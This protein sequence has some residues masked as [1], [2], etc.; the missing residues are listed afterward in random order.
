MPKNKQIS[1]FPIE[2]PLRK[3]YWDVLFQKVP[4]KP[5]VYCFL[6]SM[7]KV[8]YVGKA[9]NLRQ[10]LASYRFSNTMGVANKSLHLVTNAASLKW[11]VVASELH[12][13]IE[14]DRLIKYYLPEFN[15]VNT[16]FE[17]YYFIHLCKTAQPLK[18]EI[19]LSMS[20]ILPNSS[21]CLG[22]FKGHRQT[23]KALGAIL[24]VLFFLSLP[25]SRPKSIPITLLRKLTPNTFVVL[26]RPYTK[27]RLISFLKGK[28]FCL[29]KEFE[30]KMS[31]MISK[32]S[33][34]DAMLLED[35]FARLYSFFYKSCRP[36]NQNIGTKAF[37]HK[38]QLD[39]TLIKWSNTTKE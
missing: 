14:E 31:T 2:N 5:G 22:A 29:L 20:H 37:T 19:C 21:Y 9:K 23:R 8:I 35:D 32:I 30:H 25:K 7:G 13:L 24:R 26:L 33:T 27:N 6:D 3:S 38:N 10:R 12:A 36:L 4:K 34:V 15:V 17:H 28:H 18:W 11:K 16:Q 39:K 1:L